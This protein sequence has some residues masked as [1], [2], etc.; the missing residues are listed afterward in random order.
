MRHTK[1]LRLGRAV[2]AAGDVLGYPRAVRTGQPAGD[3]PGQRIP[4]VF[5]FAFTH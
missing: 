2:R 3:V 5:I 1:Q 4:Q